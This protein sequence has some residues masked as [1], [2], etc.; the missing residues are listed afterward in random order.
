MVFAEGLNVFDHGFRQDVGVFLGKIGMGEKA[1]QVRADPE[2]SFQAVHGL[3]RNLDGEE[4]DVLGGGFFHRVFSPVQMREFPAGGQH[5][6]GLG[7]GRELAG[8]RVHVAADGGRVHLAVD[9]GRGRFGGAHE[10]DLQ[11]LVKIIVIAVAQ[12]GVGFIPPNDLGNAA[13]GDALAPEVGHAL[14]VLVAGHQPGGRIGIDADEFEGR[15]LGREGLFALLRQPVDALRG[16]HHGILARGG[17]GIELVDVVGLARRFR[18]SDAQGIIALVDD[19]LQSR[20]QHITA[21]AEGRAEQM[22]DRFF[23][24]AGRKSGAQ[25]AD[26]KT[27]Q[28]KRQAFHGISFPNMEQIREV[29]T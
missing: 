15:A 3:G 23:G 14:D 9:Q 6:H 24:R 20:A 5:F 11:A 1:V 17:V 18:V 21:G 27:R 10:L 8:H 4:P 2:G 12:Q 25:R 22:D 28:D 29:N 16:R 13:H 26:H 19:A 7:R